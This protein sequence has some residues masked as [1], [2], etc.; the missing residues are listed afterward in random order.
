MWKKWLRFEG[1]KWVKAGIITDEQLQLIM[2]SYRSEYKNPNLILYYIAGI[3]F[4]LGILAEIA[5]NWNNI[6]PLYKLLI[7]TVGTSVFYLTGEILTRKQHPQLGAI[8]T[9]LGVITFGSGLI[10]CGQMFQWTPYDA[11]VF[12]LWSI[13]SIASL[14][15]YRKRSL[16]LLS[17]II[18]VIGQ[19]YSVLNFDSTSWGLLLV[20]IGLGLYAQQVKTPFMTWA[21]TSA[22]IIQT[23]WVMAYGT[24]LSFTWVF[25][26]L[27]AFYVLA[28]LL[29]QTPWKQPLQLLPT[30]TTF[31]LAIFITP[32]SFTQGLLIAGLVTVSVIFKAIRKEYHQMMD[33]LLFLPFCFILIKPELALY[34]LIYYIATFSWTIH[35]IIQGISKESRA[36]TNLGSLLFFITIFNTYFYVA[37][38]F[39]P[40]STFFLSSGLLLL[41]INLFL[42]KLKPRFSKYIAKERM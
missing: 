19:I 41:L 30:L 34:K 33:L 9:G 16:F 7:I 2:G 11:R 20:T 22:L 29:N 36:K 27:L 18:A 26:V 14:Y 13:I 23:L 24:T 21:T 1:G 42:Q 37:W 35:M 15:L 38:D 25:P 31:F 5:A 28:D 39:M 6:P 17:L 10:L 40:K 32:D 4:S 3:L 12:I 8:A